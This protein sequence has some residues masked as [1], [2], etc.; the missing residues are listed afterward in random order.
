MIVF[1]RWLVLAQ[2]L[3]RYGVWFAGELLL[4]AAVLV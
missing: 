4:A 2:R 1:D 3:A